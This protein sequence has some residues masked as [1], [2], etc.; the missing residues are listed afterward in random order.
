MQR[1]Y[2]VN[3]LIVS[4]TVASMLLSGCAMGAAPTTSSQYAAAPAAE[5]GAAAY[6]PAPAYDNDMPAEPV[7]MFFEDYGVRGFVTTEKDNLSTFA[8]D[9]DTGAYTVARAYVEDG[10]LP[11]RDS[12]RAEEFVNYFD[13]RYLN[14]AREETFGINIDGA[15]TPFLDRANNRMVRVGIQSYAIPAD[16]RKDVAL[17]FVIDVSGSMDMDNRLGLAKRALY[18]LVD[19]L[20]PTDE[21]A[22][23][24]Y[25]D[26]ARGGEGCHPECH[27]TAGGRRRHQR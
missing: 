23:V 8:V 4:A 2:F 17:T 22:I 26:A 19:E 10:L 1:Q 25:G 15:A 18:E 14:P 27:R 5:V 9:V 13:Y 12:V 11:E 21:V 3:R 16:E 6:A 20:R 7:D 24:V